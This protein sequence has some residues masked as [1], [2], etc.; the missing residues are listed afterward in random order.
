[1]PESTVISAAEPADP[2]DGR[3]LALVTTIGVEQ[4]RRVA[5]R[6]ALPRTQ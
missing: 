6:K 4:A 1:M 5:E 2:H 3:L